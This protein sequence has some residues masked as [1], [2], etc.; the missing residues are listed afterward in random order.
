MIAYAGEDVSEGNTH[1]LL[2]EMQTYAATVK[3]VWRFLRKLGVNLPQVPA[4]PLLGIYPRDALTYYKSICST[5]YVYVH[6]ST[7]CNSQNLETT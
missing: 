7:I 5:A 2:V 3:S 4:I 1:L 6:S